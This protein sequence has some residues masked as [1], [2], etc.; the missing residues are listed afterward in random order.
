MA[1]ALGLVAS[2]IAVADVAVKA[3]SAYVKITRLWDQVKQVPAALREK[4]EEIRLF[5]EFL[6]DTERNLS[7]GQFPEL[8]PNHAFLERLVTRCHDTLNELHD[9]VDQMYRRVASQSR[10]KRKIAS[11]KAV[12]NKDD[13]EALTS[14]FD[15]ALNLFQRA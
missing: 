15:R 10:L 11:A 8:T 9:S 4:T 2:V 7:Q 13:L 3:G 5:E 6:L 12:L 14:K 1:E